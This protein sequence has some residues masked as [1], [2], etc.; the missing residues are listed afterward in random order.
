MFSCTHWSFP[1][2]GLGCNKQFIGSSLTWLMLI[3]LWEIHG[4]NDIMV[5]NTVCVLFCFW[6]TE[7]SSTAIN[8][9][10]FT[11]TIFPF[12]KIYIK[13]MLDW[14]TYYFHEYENNIYWRKCRLDSFDD[15]RKTFSSRPTE[16][17]WCPQYSLEN[18]L[19]GLYCHIAENFVLPF[20]SCFKSIKLRE[21]FRYTY[22]I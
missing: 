5:H 4:L 11:A 7:H 8:I 6:Y 10:E 17:D 2:K 13:L 14:R 9:D 19:R 22:Y 21:R 1:F 18:I 20:L 15:Q 16:I 3:C 12:F